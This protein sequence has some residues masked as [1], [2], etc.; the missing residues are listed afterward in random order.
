MLQ[1][2]VAMLVFHD[3]P[4]CRRSGIQD[5]LHEQIVYTWWPS[6]VICSYNSLDHESLHF[7][8]QSRELLDAGASLHIAARLT[9][10][11]AVFFAGIAAPIP[12]EGH[13]ALGGKG[14]FYE[15]W[16]W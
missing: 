6:A 13:S 8:S 11:F 5:T 16:Y 7:D 14:G 15:Q 1:V 12:P 3:E 4:T 2:L 9:Q 10:T